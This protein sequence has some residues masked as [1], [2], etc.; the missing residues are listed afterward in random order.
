MTASARDQSDYETGAKPGLSAMALF[1]KPGNL[2]DPRSSISKTI[3]VL[4][5]VRHD[6]INRTLI[7]ILHP[8]A[9]GTEVFKCEAHQGH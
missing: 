1:L 9:N 6:F 2:N 4:W 3:V 7:V 5:H 8:P